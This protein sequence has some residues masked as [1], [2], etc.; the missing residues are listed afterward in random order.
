[1]AWLNE[2]K[3]AGAHVVFVGDGINDTAALAAAHVGVAMGGGA[4]AALLAADVTLVEDS[5][6]PVAAA[7]RAGRITK[8]TLR[9]NA[10]GSVLYN[11][12]AVTAA[13]FGL[14]NPLIAALLMP[15]SSLIVILAALSIERKLAHGHRTHPAPAL[16]D[17]R[18]AL[19][20]DVCESRP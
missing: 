14:V 19:C 10:I 4:T 20:L 18:S 6:A 8:A 5:I 1:V 16:D 12:T 9:R 15:A 11:A 17:A 7:I 3:A 13:A 2:R